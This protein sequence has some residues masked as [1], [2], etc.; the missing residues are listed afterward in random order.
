[1][2][3]EVVVI[4]MVVIIIFRNCCERKTCKPIVLSRTTFSNIGSRSGS[5]TSTVC[6]VQIVHT[7]SLNKGTISIYE[8]LLLVPR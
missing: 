1:M 2:W 8:L 3:K 6:S 4:A 7:R 5:N